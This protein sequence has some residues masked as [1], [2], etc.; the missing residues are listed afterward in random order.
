MKRRW[1]LLAFNLVLA[2]AILVQP[3]RAASTCDFNDCT[4]ACLG[5]W[6]NCFTD[7]D[8]VRK[9][10]WLYGFCMWWTGCKAEPTRL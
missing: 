3:G 2:T 6:D 4:C 1:A 10:D 8:E 7:W 5:V 9:C